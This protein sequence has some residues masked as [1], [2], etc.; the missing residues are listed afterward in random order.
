MTIVEFL[1]ARL[2]EDEYEAKYALRYAITGD[3]LDERWQWSHQYKPTTRKHG[4]SSSLHDGVP[5][6]TRVLAEVAAKRRIMEY[7]AEASSDRGQV[8]SEFAVGNDE[9][10]MMWKADPGDAILR[11]LAV[12]YADHPD[13]RQEWKP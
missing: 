10:E 2:D 6:P 7:A 8:I 1:T 11:A 4:W 9:V 12:V 13:Y 3:D 5:S